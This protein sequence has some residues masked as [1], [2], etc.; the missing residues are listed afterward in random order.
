MQKQ[1]G[2]E[3]PIAFG[4]PESPGISSKADYDSVSLRW[5]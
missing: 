3:V 4:S 2:K 1:K 5:G